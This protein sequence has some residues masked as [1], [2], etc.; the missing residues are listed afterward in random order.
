MSTVVAVLKFALEKF[1]TDQ[2]E[3]EELEKNFKILEFPVTYSDKDD[4][5]DS[6][7]PIIKESVRYIFAILRIYFGSFKKNNY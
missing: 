2:C 4:G 7:I 3:K 1:E 6:K 5:S